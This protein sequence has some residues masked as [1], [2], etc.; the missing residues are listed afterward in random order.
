MTKKTAIHHWIWRDARFV[1]TCGVSDGLIDPYRPVEITCKNCLRVL[2]SR[3]WDL[4]V[5]AKE[6]FLNK[7]DNPKTVP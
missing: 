4:E 3:G 7:F 6:N 1:L 2:K 5:E